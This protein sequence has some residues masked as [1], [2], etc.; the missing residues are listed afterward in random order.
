MAR[1]Q[2]E[3]RRAEAI[4]TEQEIKAKVAENRANLVL[5][6]AS[7]PRAMADAFTKGRLAV[8]NNN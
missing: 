8:S 2:A 6:E 1:A 5:A 7:V 3:R 4:A